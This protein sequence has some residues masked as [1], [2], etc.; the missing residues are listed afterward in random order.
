MPL[1]FDFPLDK[2]QTYQGINP[3]PADFDAYWD[4]ALA[5]MHALDP[6]MELVPAEFQAPGAECFHLYFTG[7]GGA[8]LRRPADAPGETV[9]GGV[10]ETL[11]Q[12]FEKSS[13][14]FGR[15]RRREIG[16]ETRAHLPHFGFGTA[17]GNAVALRQ[18]A[19]PACTATSTP[20]SLASTR[21]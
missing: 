1:T 7:V 15:R 8:L 3:R 4:A 20:P 2:L 9:V 21:S 10:G 12:P 14:R 13:R 16:E 18:L 17:G 5:E 11:A 6:Q 19:A